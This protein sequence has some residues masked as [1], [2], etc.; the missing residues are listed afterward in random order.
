MSLISLSNVSVSFGANDILDSV[1]CEANLHERIGL[2]GRNGAGKTTLLHV[3][4]GLERA[5]TGRRHAAGWLRSVIV[6]QIPASTGDAVTVR[7]E[8]LSSVQDVVA[9]EAALA[10][11]ATAMARGD[12]EAGEHYADLLQ[13]MESEG[14]FTYEARFA[15][16]MSGLGFDEDDWDKT[17]AVLSGGQRSRV[18][19]ARAL[20]SEPDLLLM[21]EPT[22]HL[23]LQGLRWLES[24]LSAWHGTLVVTSHDR[25]FL[26]KVATRIWQVESRRLRSYP[27][28]YSKY[29]ALRAADT[30]RQQRELERQ[31]EY[32]AKQEAFIRRY[33]AGQRAAEA[34]GRAKRLAR[35]ERIEAPARQRSVRFNFRSRRS[36]EVVL[37]TQAMT[38]GHEDTPVLEVGDLELER[39]ARV[40]LVG[41]NG[42]GKSTLLRTISGDLAPVEGEASLG[43]NVSVAHY[44]QEAEGLD[45]SLTVLQELLRDDPDIQAARDLAGRFLFGGEE[46]TKS[47]GNLSGGERSRLALAKLVRSGANL[48]LLDEPTNHLDIPSREALEDALTAFD[49]TLLFASHDRRLIDRLANRLWVIEDGR[50]IQ[51]DGSLAEYDT[52]VEPETVTAQP[53]PEGRPQQLSSNEQRRLDEALGLLEAAITDKE[54]E[55][56][57][58][59]ESIN[60]ASREG[61]AALVGELGLRF[62][63]LR[64]EVEQL[65]IQWTDQNQDATKP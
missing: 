59:E 14:A 2:V 45:G 30:E 58:L 8:V 54:G 5:R 41:R 15:Q 49:G 50:L 64:E 40:A 44:W 19:L 33:G 43:A 32:V 38:V 65:L 61:D 6:E 63:A 3:L 11:A 31:K 46:V 1:T 28:N 25:Y 51:F 18:G 13:R 42:A 4:A 39:G 37:R 22:N 26:D 47:V 20:M 27:G 29:E 60:R 24:F 52:K 17:L 62:E 9:L 48:L 35:L 21:D 23:D 55:I 16:I 53:K 36:G 34:Q 7:D 10:A 56:E 12:A 57:S